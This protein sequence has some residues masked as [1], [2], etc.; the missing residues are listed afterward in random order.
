LLRYADRG[1][2]ANPQAL[3]VVCEYLRVR[4]MGTRLA[5]LTFF[6]AR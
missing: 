1:D 6:A 2:R 4:G 5:V 3:Q